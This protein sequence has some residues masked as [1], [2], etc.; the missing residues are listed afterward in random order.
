MHPRRDSGHWRV[1]RQGIRAMGA[2]SNSHLGSASLCYIL[3][4]REALGSHDGGAI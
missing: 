4:M 3:S 2:A 1:I